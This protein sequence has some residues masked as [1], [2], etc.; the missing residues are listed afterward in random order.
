MI[1][2]A[3][4]LRKGHWYKCKNGHFY[5]IGECGGAM[6]ES[7][8]PECNETIGG[9][10]HRLAEGN[11]HAGEFDGSRHAA[12]SEGANLENFNLADLE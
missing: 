8:C 10:N 12:W 4:G 6:Q 5:A 2:K 7:K 3:V 9:A 11:E 1:V